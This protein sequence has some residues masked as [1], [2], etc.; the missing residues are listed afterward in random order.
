MG[1]L[2]GVVHLIIAGAGA[3]LEVQSLQPSPQNL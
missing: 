2:V 3:E 1:A